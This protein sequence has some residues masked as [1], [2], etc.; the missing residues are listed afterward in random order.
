MKKV[1]ESLAKLQTGSRPVCCL[2]ALFLLVPAAEVVAGSFTYVVSGDAV[3]VT[4][5]YNPGPMPENISVIPPTIEGKP[6]TSIGNSAFYN[7]SP[8]NGYMMVSVTIPDSVT[9][10]G[11]RA[12]GNNMGL[13]SATIGNG[14]VSIGDY[15]FSSCSSMT[16]VTM[17]ANV[18]N[19]GNSAFYWCGLKD[20]SMPDSVTSIGASAFEQ[21]MS[22]MNLTIGTNVTN[23]GSS[24]FKS[25][26]FLT[27]VT[28]PDSVISIGASAFYQCNQLRNITIGTNV[29]SIGDSAFYWCSGL[30]DVNIP[31][32]VISIGASAFNQCGMLTNVII[33]AGVTNIG[34]S[35]FQFCSGLSGIYFYGN[36]PS[37][38]SD[39]FLNDNTATVYHLAG[40][41]DW[42]TVPDAWA[43]RP[44][45]LWEP[46]SNGNGI[47][48]SWEQQYFGGSTNANPNAVCSNGINTVREC[49]IAGLNPNDRQSMLRASSPSNNGK[50]FGWNSVSGRV[51]SVYWTTNL[52]NGF[53]CL[54]SNIPWTRGNFTN[55]AAVPCGYYK[56]DVRLE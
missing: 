52:L 18:K 12:F 31:G 8:M 10:I 53:Q 56:I 38:G 23:I 22:L 11:F 47:P 13:K 34:N 7:P 5:Y 51:Y 20:M 39:V 36:A 29:T 16:N 14:V 21:C 30:T 33:G 9:N 35:A 17:G 41:T 2:S 48:D 49:Y 40:A 54:E 27:S 37:F 43:G 3:T 46:D 15:A 50:V 4:G 6:V 25:C 1:W 55:S 42:P 44:T 45:A 28:I 32:N 19:I 26:A 24:A